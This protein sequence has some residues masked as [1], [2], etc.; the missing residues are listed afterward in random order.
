MSGSVSDP[1]MTPLLEA[2]SLSKSFGPTHALRNAGIDLRGGE[3]HALVGEN[4]AGKSTLI[5]ILA[6][7]FPRDAGSVLLDGEEIAPANPRE[8]RT[9]GISTVFQELSLASNMTVAENIF[10]NREP[11]RLGLVRRKAMEDAA[12]AYLRN[13]NVQL[14]PRDRVAELTVA[15]RQIV[16]IVKAVSVD[17]RV[18]ILDEPTSSLD[19]RESRR[20]FELLDRLRNDGTGIIFVSHKLNEVFRIADR[21]TVFRDGEQIMTARAGTTTQDEVIRAMVG[22]EISQV[23]PPKAS[24]KGRAK[25]S[26][27]AFSLR[28]KIPGHRAHGP[29]EGNPGPGGTDRCGAHGSDAGALRV[30]TEGLGGCSSLTERRS[31]S[32]PPPRRYAWGSCTRPR[33]GACTGCSFREASR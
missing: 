19:D 23:F 27:A 3:I 25:L 31:G 12:G 21:I 2:R 4:G 29:R 13:F 24:G 26:C 5:K 22:R 14:D 17:A 10:V 18:L 11:V 30:R 7:V 28:G 15:Q 20:L 32:R 1:G 9:L 16:E 6:G 8:A 33:T